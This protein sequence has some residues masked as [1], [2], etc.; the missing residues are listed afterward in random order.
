MWV[1]IL[2]NGDEGMYYGSY[3]LTQGSRY[4]RRSHIFFP[5]GGGYMLGYVRWSLCSG[6]FQHSH[7]E[8]PREKPHSETLLV[9][10]GCDQWGV[11][12]L[13]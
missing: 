7:S 3:I 13:R 6:H 4:G 8:D 9:H 10:L 11:A 2:V 5:E 12:I 1:L